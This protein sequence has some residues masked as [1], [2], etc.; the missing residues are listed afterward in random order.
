MVRSFTA[1]F[2]CAVF[3]AVASAATAA[4]TPDPSTKGADGLATAIFAGGCFWCM[5]PPFD[6]L[7]GVTATTSGYTGGTLDNPSYQQVSAGGTGHAEAV[8][9]T[10]DPARVDYQTLLDV[11]WHNVDPLD[12]G[13]QFCDRGDSYRTAIF[14]ADDTQKQ[15][16]EASKAALEQSGRFKTAIVMAIVPATTFYPAEDYHQDYYKK[17]SIRYKFYRYACGRDHRLEELWGSEAGHKSG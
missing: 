17:N 16:A 4:D 6:A 13:G 7:D 9:V 8:R 14:Y 5:E 10:Y 1:S 12:A 15:L 3:L 11:Y 2:L